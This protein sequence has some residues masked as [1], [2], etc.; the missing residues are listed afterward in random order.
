MA[1]LLCGTVQAQSRL[2]VGA[3]NLAMGG[4]GVGAS[5]DAVAVHYNPAGMAFAGG[6]EF[7][8]P[9]V[10]LDA[11]LEGDILRSVDELVTSFEQDSL[12][13][14]QDRLDTGQGSF[15][16]LQTV[17]DVF[18]D[19][20]P[21]L[22]TNDDGV[23]A[24]AAA[25]P[26]LRFQN[27]AVPAYYSGS[28]GLDS[29]IDLNA[30]LALSAAGLDGAIPDP[31]PADAC[32]A[33]PVCLAHADDLVQETGIDPARAEVLV[34]ASGEALTE[35]PRAFDILTGIVD[36][37][38]NGGLTLDE[39]A[40]EV[41][42]S[43]IV[44]GQVAFSWSRLVYRDQL[45]VGFNAKLMSGTTFIERTTVGQIEDGY[46]SFDELFDYDNTQTD[47]DFGIDL[48]LMYR[49]TPRWSIGLAADNINTPAFEFALIRRAIEMKPLFRA[50][51]AYRPLH[52]FNAA[53]DLDLNEVD[54]G[55]VRGLGYRY[56]NLGVEF[57]VGQWFA[58]RLGA[59]R[60]LAADRSSTIY[61]G[62]LGFG[63]K[64]FSIDLTL[65]TAANRLQ[66]RGG[67]DSL[68]IPQGFAAALQFNWRPKLEHRQRGS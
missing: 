2:F 38:V 7:Q 16:D 34:A 41:V 58:G 39:N 42:R 46:D 49:P 66:I 55:V 9:L 21:D 65:A 29:I 30:A 24:R 67:D 31:V 35:N 32:N 44:I 40:S 37:T 11:E 53:V 20:L 22:D 47:T 5:S 15:Q 62:G 54:S 50:G 27:W 33:D 8:L 56:T 19:V 68:S 64:R 45:S 12:G 25:G 59:Y 6:W 13:E 52:W 4:T 61:T 10:T 63:F 23:V 51:A 18:L 1:L 17:L 3:R 28:A 48:G 57:L 36:A 14:I 26:S 60:N 43:G